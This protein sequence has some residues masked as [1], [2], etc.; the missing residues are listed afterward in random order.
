MAKDLQEKKQI[1]VEEGKLL[2]Q[3]LTEG[4]EKL[5]AREKEYNDELGEL[6]S[7]INLQ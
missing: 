2:R 3:Q 5:Q 7:K 1:L 4:Q 6:K